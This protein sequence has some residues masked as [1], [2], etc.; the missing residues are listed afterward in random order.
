MTTKTAPAKYTAPFNRHTGLLIIEVRNSN[1]NG[2]PD[3]ESDP[4]T[5][6][7]DGR[8]LISPVSVKRKIRDLVLRDGDVIAAA[9]ARLSLGANGDKNAYG[10]L[11]SRGRN[12]A[13]IEALDKEDFQGRYW[14]ART[15]GTTF[16]EGKDKGGDDDEPAKGKG[17]SKGNAKGSPKP[18]HFIATGVIQ[19]GVGVSAAPVEIIRW[20]QTNFAGVQEGKDRGMAPLG[21]RVVSHGLYAIPWFANPE[22]A[23]KTRATALDLELFKFLLPK[24]YPLTTSAS[25]TQVFP[26]HCWCAEHT[27]PWGSCPDPLILDALTPRRKGAAQPSAA[28]SDYDIPKELPAELRARLKSFKDLCID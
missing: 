26:V 16:L 22:L 2:D 5:F 20:T 3:V 9:G 27:S 1:P 6:E 10:I 13:E 23:R 11:E 8:G 15:F 28:L 19:V 25:R 4:R 21:F 7:S 14:D 18:D 12:R 24:A 17:K